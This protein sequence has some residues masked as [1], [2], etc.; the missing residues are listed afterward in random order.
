MLEG[1]K[2][3]VPYVR[4]DR[5]YKFDLKGAKETIITPDK[6]N[7]LYVAALMVPLSDSDSEYPALQVGNYLL[8]TAPLAS[9]LSNRVRG[10][11]G[12]SYGIRSS[13]TAE[14]KDKSARF[15]IYAITNPKNIGKV[16]TAIS[17]EV[18][19]FLKDGISLSELEEG[20]QA[21]LQSLKVQRSSDSVIAS[22][23]AS[24]LFN[25]R[26]FEF[27]ADSR[28]RSWTSSRATSSRPGR[29]CWIPRS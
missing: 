12:L 25:G 22:Q 7:A 27:Y 26:T 1:W 29:R 10:K 11:E 13:F 24:G 2:A 14:A 3:S 21:Y 18:Q 20:K 28:K 6:E 15:M 4:I 23:L 19:K 5:P 16:D 8:G 17:D 9:R